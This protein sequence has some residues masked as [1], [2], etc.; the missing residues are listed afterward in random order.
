MA[1]ALLL[2]GGTSGLVAHDVV[3]PCWRGQAGGTVQEWNFLTSA[4]PVNA[5]TGTNPYGTAQA[6]ITQ[7]P[8][9]DGYFASWPNST[10]VGFWDLG[11][12]GSIS[13]Q[14]PNRPGTPTASAKYIWV[15]VFQYIGGV[16]PNY[17]SYSIPG[18]TYL[19][20]QR[21]LVESV[22]PLGGVYVDQTMWRLEPNP[23]SE[24]LTIMAPS[25]GSLIDQIVVDTLCITN[26]NTYVDASY[27]GSD[28]AAVGWPNSVAPL[29]KPLNLLAFANLQ[30]GVDRAPTNGIV[31]VAAGTYTAVNVN[32]AVTVNL[33]APTAQAT[34][35]GLTL[36]A[37]ATLAM[38]VNGTNPGSQYDQWIVNGG[39]NLGGATLALSAGSLAANSTLVIIANDSTDA[40]VGTFA[41]MPAG[42]T[43]LL[44]GQQ[45]TINY[46]GGDGNDVVLT[47]LN[48]A[49][50][51][52][53]YK[54][55]A[56]DQ[57]VPATLGFAKLMSG[58]TDPD[59][60]DTVSF[61]NVMAA[62]A[63]GGSLTTNSQG[64]T[65]TPPSIIS[66][67]NYLDYFYYT[68]TDGKAVSTGTVTVE[69]RSANAITFNMLPLA[70]SNNVPYVRFAGSP[71]TTYTLQRS[72]D[73]TNWTFSVSVPTGT[74]GIGAYLDTDAPNTNG[75]YRTRYP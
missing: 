66:G 74:N 48:H 69:V 73:M 11:Q 26:S 58:A 10:N 6:A 68:I 20:G 30:T 25:N 44:G 13:V 49:P 62:S 56:T 39:V 19:G 14:I 60:G 50:I 28:C 7:G 51:P 75:F 23:S 45:F 3:I 38:D 24:T 9:S 72:G 22:P 70:I 71:S 2:A 5:E 18:A 41:G 61:A 52:A 59:P 55:A 4:N 1:I 8:Y 67:T 33:G 16:F 47:M 63:E 15:Q 64:V 31:N 32:K 65:Y 34:V 53:A 12:S 42:S 40:V 35:A 43:N 54:F 57:G 29:D 27:S 21:Q 36:G 17:A 46:A 37:A